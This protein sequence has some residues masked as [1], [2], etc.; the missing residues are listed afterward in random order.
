MRLPA[1]TQPGLWFCRAAAA[2]VAMGSLLSV[3]LARAEEASV[4]PYQGVE[5]HYVLHLPPVRSGPMP[6]VIALLGLNETV[7]ALRHSWTL[8]AVPLNERQKQR[9]HGDRSQ[10]IETAE[11]LWRFFSAP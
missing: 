2:A 6:L 5:R 4:F 9:R 11:E 7:E 10:A 8:D 3:P 1:W